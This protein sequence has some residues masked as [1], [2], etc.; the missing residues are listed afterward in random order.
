MTQEDNTDSEV[1]SPSKQDGAEFTTQ[2]IE[3]AQEEQTHSTDESSTLNE[4]EQDG[5]VD[6]KKAAAL[7]GAAAVAGAAALTTSSEPA[8]ATELEFGEVSASDVYDDDSI[9]FDG[10]DFRFFFLTDLETPV[11]VTWE[12]EAGD[13]L[14]E[15]SAIA[16]LEGLSEDEVIPVPEREV[17]V[18]TVSESAPLTLR[19]TLSHPQAQD[20]VVERTYPDVTVT[21]LVEVSGDF[22]QVPHSHPG[23][24]YTSET[25]PSSPQGLI[26]A[27][28]GPSNATP[29]GWDL[30][31]GSNNTPDLRDRFIVGAGDDYS[32]GDT[33]GEEEVTLSVSQLP[34]H[35]HNYRRSRN[36]NRAGNNQNALNRAFRN[37]NTG[38]TG[39]GEAHNNMPPYYAL[40]YI[41]KN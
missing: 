33:G 36:T 22:A 15:D 13:S 34:S 37:R 14:E 30:C 6:M 32:V 38:N 29:D 2:P 8:L 24:Y 3:E 1:G 39:G 17:D 12:V 19:V 21:S 7:S 27:W 20:L 9:G 11:T 23:E 41:K 40:A 25:A 31:D 28:S 16:P 5:S 10:F 26:I 4:D 18:P 35:R